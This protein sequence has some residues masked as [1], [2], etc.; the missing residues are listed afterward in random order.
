MFHRPRMKVIAWAE[1]YALFIHAATLPRF[2]VLSLIV[3]FFPTILS[4]GQLL[5]TFTLYG[6]CNDIRHPSCS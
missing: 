2:A 5:L 3:T 4:F 1:E 6:F